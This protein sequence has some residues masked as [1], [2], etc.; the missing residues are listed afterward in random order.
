MTAVFGGILAQEIVKLTGQF[1]PVEQQLLYIADP[2]I[3]AAGLDE[4]AGSLA[5]K[6]D[7]YDDLR[8]VIGDNN[9]AK[10]AAAKIFMVGSGALGCELLKNFALSGMA[11]TSA[12]GRCTVTDADDVE[13]SNLNRQFLFR[14]PD[15]KKPKSTQA[16]ARASLMNPDF[17]TDAHTVFAAPQTENLFT[18]DFWDELD[19]VIPALDTVKARKYVDGKCAWHRVAEFESGTEGLKCH[20]SSMIPCKTPCWTDGEA[21]GEAGGGPAEHSC[22][23][24]QYPYKSEHC[25]VHAKFNFDDQFEGGVKLAQDF[26]R[27]PAAARKVW[28]DDTPQG[29]KGKIIKTLLVARPAVKGTF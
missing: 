6:G 22:T 5:P 29:A 20:A 24:K 15:V 28:A 11:L 9:V 17:C 23:V 4:G 27:D 10:L 18:D 7:R 14:A 2:F 16:C 21:G 8:A 1:R 25:V 13:R 12:G 26:T 3:A 19:L